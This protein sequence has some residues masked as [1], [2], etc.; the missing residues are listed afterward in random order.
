MIL[1]YVSWRCNLALHLLLVVFP[2]IKN[3]WCLLSKPAIAHQGFAFIDIIS[4]C[5]TF[6]NHQGSTRSYDY[7]QEHV[8]TG[9][10][11]DFVPIEEEITC[12]VPKGSFE[13]ICLHD[14]SVMRI[15]K[16]AADYDTGDRFKAVQDIE[17]HKGRGE[18]LT[19]LLHLDATAQHFHEL[20]NTADTPLNQLKQDQLC[21]GERVIGTINDSFR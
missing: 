20:N 13:D 14:G 12:E 2:V 18:I 7:V 1:I 16:L 5:V 17:A 19:G 6:N 8:T 21:P 9:A 10:V 4:P 15:R 3:N 11:I